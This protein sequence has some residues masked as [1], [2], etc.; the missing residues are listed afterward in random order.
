MYHIEAFKAE[1]M[2]QRIRW[3]PKVRRDKIR[4][5]YE[6]DAQGIIDEEL[7]DEVACA[8][9][10]RCENIL[11][12]TEASMGRVK[13]P[14]CGNIIL[15]HGV[16]KEQVLKCKECL[17][18]ITWGEYFQSYHQK[19]L[20]GGGAV[21]VFKN[22]IRQLPAVR[23]PQEKMILIDRIIHECHIDLKKQQYNRPVAVNLIS[24]TMIQ[25][26]NFLD[27]LAYGQGS[28]PGS[29]DIQADWRNKMGDALQRW[30]MSGE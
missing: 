1:N 15:R 26:I 8:F 25:I 29:K 22:F 23:S 17:W 9:Y 10:A 21:E 14:C 2:S 19:Q 13:C 16:D 3:A 30:R 18:E 7:I 20:H 6:T 28:T 27:D 4:R 5:L 24:G 11:T 12:V